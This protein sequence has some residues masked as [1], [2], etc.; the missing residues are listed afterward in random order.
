MKRTTPN[1]EEL[2]EQ[3]AAAP[4]PPPPDIVIDGGVTYPPPEFVINIFS[5]DLTPALSVVNATAVALSD[6]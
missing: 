2:T 3:V 4:A 6:V 5:I 1:P